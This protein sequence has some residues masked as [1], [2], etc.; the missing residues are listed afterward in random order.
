[1]NESLSLVEDGKTK[2]FF[3]R[4]V[5]EESVHSMEDV[6]ECLARGE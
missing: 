4:G 3:I 1:M 2:D 5:T 6:L